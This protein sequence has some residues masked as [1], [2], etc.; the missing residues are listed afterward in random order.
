MIANGVIPAPTSKAAPDEE[1]L[2]ERASAPTLRDLREA[3]KD[4]LA[5]I[6]TE[7]DSSSPDDG[8]PQHIRE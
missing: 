4:L 8:L 2:L 5:T 6:E 7:T 3:H 1:A